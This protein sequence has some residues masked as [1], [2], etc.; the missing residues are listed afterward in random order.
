MAVQW[1]PIKA[2]LVALLP[3]LPGWVDLIT[4][5][6]GRCPTGSSPA[7]YATVAYTTNGQTGN[8]RFEQAPDGFRLI[9]TGGVPIELN[10]SSGSE[11]PAVT[12]ALVVAALDGLEAAIR[13]DRTLG[14]I[15]S[16]EGYFTVSGTPTP[17]MN[18]L[19]TAYLTL[20]G[21][22]YYTVT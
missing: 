17:V 19:G 21:L 6:P 7:N 20:L 4:V 16:R 12:E 5:Y 3:T 1:H 22:N 14:G 9:E 8:Y 2:G 10:C 13:R 15:L 18:T 11:D